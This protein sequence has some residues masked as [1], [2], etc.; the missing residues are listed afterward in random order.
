MPLK[1]LHPPYRL[2]AAL[3]GVALVLA[4]AFFAGWTVNGWRLGKA[5]AEA[6]ADTLAAVI[7]KI[8]ADMEKLLSLIHI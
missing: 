1:L 4:A 3:A 6:R 8:G 2:P 5:Q 7:G